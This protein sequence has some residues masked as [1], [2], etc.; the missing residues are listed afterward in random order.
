MASHSNDKRVPA[1]KFG[2]GTFGHANSRVRGKLFSLDRTF[3]A[4]SSDIQYYNSASNSNPGDEGDYGYC[5][6]EPSTTSCSDRL[7]DSGADDNLEPGACC[8]Q[9]QEQFFDEDEEDDDE[10]S[11]GLPSDFPS[12]MV[13]VEGNII[14][15]QNVDLEFGQEDEDELSCLPNDHQINFIKK[16]KK[17]FNATKISNGKL[18]NFR[19]PHHLMISNNRRTSNSTNNNNNTDKSKLDKQLDK[20]ISTSGTST[21][22]TI[23][24]HYYPEGG[25]GYVALVTALLCHTLVWGVHLSSGI[26]ILS[27]LT[28]FN[29][30][31][32][33]IEAGKCQYIFLNKYKVTILEFLFLYLD[34]YMC[35]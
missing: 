15:P 35:T 4:S 32:P 19:N 34:I 13:D 22:S 2:R 8:D 23:T 11:I 1:S 21:S 10:F 12:G 14:D 20:Q 6:D 17:S 7:K 30:K 24:Q 3:S 26:V 33:L 9:D 31:I 16:P 5:F 18:P 29:E 27:L 25:W 28:K